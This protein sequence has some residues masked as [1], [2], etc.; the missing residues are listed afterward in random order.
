MKAWALGQPT[1]NPLRLVGAVV[2][3]DEV[4]VEVWGH[5]SFDGIEKSAEL[6]GTMTAMQ[7]T[8][9]FAAGDIEGREQ[10]GGAV[11]GMG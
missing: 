3:Q 8:Q 9:H 5:V 6:A 11:A 7:L 4:H 10:T 1:A 2:I